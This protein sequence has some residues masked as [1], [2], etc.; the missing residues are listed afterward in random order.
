M[1]RNCYQAL[2]DILHVSDPLT[3][4]THAKLKKVDEFVDNFRVKCKGRFQPYRNVAIDERLAK[5][6][7]RSGIRQ[8]NAN[9]PAK[10]GLKLWVIADSATGYT[11]TPM[12]FTFTQEK[13]IYST[14]M[15]LAVT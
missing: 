8:Y 10:F 5:S 13:Q 11:Y 15:V 4:D 9:K 6:K 3:E 7:Y 14:Q 1:S 12:T 2:L